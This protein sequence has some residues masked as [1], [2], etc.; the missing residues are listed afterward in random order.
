MN[1]SGRAPGKR[2]R[3]RARIIE[4]ARSLFAEHG[5]ETVSMDDVA[6]EA[7]VSRTTVF[8]H[9]PTKQALLEG[10]TERILEGYEEL[11]A[12]SL[13]STGT[14]V[15]DRVRRLFR[16]MGRGVTRESRLHRAVFREISRV[17]LTPDE[18]GRAFVIRREAIERL[19]QLMTQGQAAGELRTDVMAQHLASAFDS[20]VFGTVAFWMMEASDSLQARMKLNAELFLDMAGSS[21][22]E[23]SR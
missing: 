23:R 3:S 8:N 9:F 16:D 20:L 10:V 18:P 12:G 2:E 7:R 1:R 4:A 17:M 22:G 13:R 5:F 21:G 15:V 11:L 6:A 14:T 19:T